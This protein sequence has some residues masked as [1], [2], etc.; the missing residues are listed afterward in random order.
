M[1]VSSD[2]DSAVYN[3]AKILYRC[4]HAFIIR[5]IEVFEVDS[6]MYAIT[7]FCKRGDLQQ[8]QKK[9]CNGQLMEEEDVKVIAKKIA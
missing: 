9:I 5:C 2:N 8:Y 4:S 6:K 7:E 3:E 1:N